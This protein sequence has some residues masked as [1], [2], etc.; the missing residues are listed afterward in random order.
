MNANMTIGEALAAVSRGERLPREIA[1][2]YRIS[3]H[4]T[5]P[6]SE[7]KTKQDGLANALQMAINQIE[8]G[9]ASEA[10]LQLVNLLDDVCA[11][12]NPYLIGEKPARRK[13]KRAD[14]RGNVNTD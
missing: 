12:S 2:Q 13:S 7:P 14:Y 8:A 9:N 11:E 5:R 4:Y 3:Q 1:E 10:L 6:I